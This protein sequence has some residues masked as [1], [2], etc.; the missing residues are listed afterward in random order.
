MAC[1]SSAEL[2]LNLIMA[3]MTLAYCMPPLIYHLMLRPYRE[4]FDP[5][6]FYTAL[7]TLFMCAC[8]FMHILMFALPESNTLIAFNAGAENYVGSFSSTLVLMLVYYGMKG[9]I[10]AGKMSEQPLIDKKLPLSYLNKVNFHTTVVKIVSNPI[11][12]YLFYALDRNWPA[13]IFILINC[14]VIIFCVKLAL[15]YL[16]LICEQ[17]KIFTDKMK[18]EQSQQSVQV[19]YSGQEESKGMVIHTSGDGAVSLDDVDPSNREIPIAIRI[20]FLEK[21]HLNFSKITRM[22]R[23]FLGITIVTSCLS[24]KQYFFNDWN[25]CYYDTS[26]WAYT[27]NG[28]FCVITIF[29]FGSFVSAVKPPKLITPGQVIMNFIRCETPSRQ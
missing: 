4:K 3:I 1:I 26:L 29:G 23:L 18:A 20:A 13:L 22:L 17:L 16:R 5:A 24:C 27:V 6:E 2:I 21:Q 7:G 25:Y 14:S 15:E 11:F 10:D 9:K 19:Q 12:M 28:F 8:Y